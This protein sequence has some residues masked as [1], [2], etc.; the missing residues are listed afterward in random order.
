MMLARLVDL[1]R[2]RRTVQT[3]ARDGVLHLDGL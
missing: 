3:E 1:E 2:M